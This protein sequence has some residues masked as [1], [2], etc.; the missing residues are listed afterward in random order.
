MHAELLS[1]SFQNI[2]VF[3]WVFTLASLMNVLQMFLSS[4]VCFPCSLLNH[5]LSEKHYFLLKII[6]EIKLSVPFEAGVPVG[7][8]LPGMGS[9][10]GQETVTSYCWCLSKDTECSSEPKSLKDGS[11]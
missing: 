2:S 10:R 9:D 11:R 7:C 3:H 8:L 6:E 5:I 1:L 4:S